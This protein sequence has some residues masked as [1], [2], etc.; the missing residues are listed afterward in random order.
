MSIEI[1]CPCGSQLTGRD[2]NV[3]KAE[4]CPTCGREFVWPRAGEAAQFGPAPATGTLPKA[5][6]ATGAA[7]HT[8]SAEAASGSAANV[9]DDRPARPEA[10]EY[11][12]G[13]VAQ[14]EFSPDGRW[15]AVVQVSGKLILIRLS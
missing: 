12:V 14:L 9:A 7:M 8:T 2:E 11:A 13:P 6:R 4:R 3:G 1:T 10:Y 5:G 15:L